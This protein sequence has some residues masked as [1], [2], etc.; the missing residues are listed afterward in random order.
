MDVAAWLNTPKFKDRKHKPLCTVCKNQI[1]SFLKMLLKHSMMSILA[2]TYW[3]L[4][5]QY[6][7][8]SLTGIQYGT[9]SVKVGHNF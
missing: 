3:Q 4:L 2:T 8:A 5:C 1:K 7:D 9:Y 6:I